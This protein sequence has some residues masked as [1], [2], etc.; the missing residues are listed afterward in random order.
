MTLL[1]LIAT[2]YGASA[3]ASWLLEAA[4]LHRSGRA[5]E[6]SL[7]FLGVLL[8]GYLVWLLYGISARDA[9]LI[10]TDAVGLAASTITLSIAA[11]LQRRRTRSLARPRAHRAN[12]GRE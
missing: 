2:A 12:R 7:T 8:G 9:P 10:I 11:R 6:I 3:A 1:A 5:D 4:R